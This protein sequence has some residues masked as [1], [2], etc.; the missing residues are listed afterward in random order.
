MLRV[1]RQLTNNARASSRNFAVAAAAAPSGPAVPV[2]ATSAPPVEISKGANGI[3]VSTEALFSGP[4][5]A[6]IAVTVGAGSRVESANVNGIASFTAAASIDS[7][8]AEGA[9]MGGHFTATTD[10]EVTTFSATV[11]TADMPAAMALLGKAVCG[12]VGEVNRDARAMQVDCHTSDY[13]GNV[14]DHLHEA[15]FLSNP[16]GMSPMGTTEAVGGLSAADLDAFKKSH[17][18]SNA[19]SVSVAGAGVEHGAVAGLVDKSFTPSAA[20][21]SLAHAMTPSIFTGSDKRIRFDSHPDAVVAIGFQG[22]SSTSAH[23]VPLMAARSVLGD[24]CASSPIGINSSSKLA[25]EFAENGIAK[26][27]TAFNLPYA[28]TGL[29]GVSFTATDNNLEDC[30]WYLMDNMVR[31][32]HDVTEEEVNRAKANMVTRLL[33]MKGSAQGLAT[34]NATQMATTGRVQSTAEFLTR[35]DAVTAADVK[36]AANEIINDEDHALAAVGPIFELPDYNW[37][38][39]RSY[40]HRF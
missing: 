24:W 13:R 7:I 17:Y 38:R 32:C 29:F 30:M 34:F 15:A 18:T 22:A 20:S 8:A 23:Y 5:V 26:N 21:S 2:Y 3:A 10:R 39:R 33:S 25:R 35:I 36:A 40:W 12:S 11:K 14:M 4:G 9:K 37:I 27:V 19:I 1:G 6:S 16:L 28:D 31:L